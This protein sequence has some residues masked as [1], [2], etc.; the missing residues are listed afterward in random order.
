MYKAKRRTLQLNAQLAQTLTEKGVEA[1]ADETTTALVDKVAEISGG[2]DDEF[3]GVKYSDFTAQCNLPK[4]ADARSLALI[5][6]NPSDTKNNRNFISSDLFVSSYSGATGNSINTELEEIY[7]PDGLTSIYRTFY[8]CRA[9]K[10]IVGDM[11]SVKGL[12]SSFYGCSSLTEIP[13]MPNLEYLESNALTRCTRLTSITFYKVLTA[14]KSNALT[15]CTNITA[16]NLADGWNIN[17]YAQ[18]CPNLTQASLHDMIEK[19]ADMT[20]KTSPVMNVGSSNLVKIDDEHKAMATAKNI[21]L[22]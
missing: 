9:L 14:W 4:K 3:I 15:G 1:T 22:A 2:G 8:N 12:S 19:Y 6:N 13:Y 16:I 10:L 11:T 17:V 20:G 21:T 18:H 5:Y 7:M